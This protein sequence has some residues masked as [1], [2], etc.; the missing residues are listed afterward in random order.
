MMS[1]FILLIFV[2][3]CGSAF[4]EAGVPGAANGPDFWEHHSGAPASDITPSSGML[5]D[6]LMLLKI[7]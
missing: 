4:A 2:L 6:T 3:G 7:F 5:H 1:L